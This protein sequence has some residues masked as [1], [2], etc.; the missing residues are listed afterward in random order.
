MTRFSDHWA[1][2]IR[3]EDGATMV[4]YALMVASIAMI[5]IS[6]VSLLGTTISSLF[7]PINKQFG[8][9]GPR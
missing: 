7:A 8:S 5:S 4:E 3:E 9:A 1:R 2:L 6:T